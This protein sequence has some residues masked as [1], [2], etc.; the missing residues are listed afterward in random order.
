MNI[1]IF[2]VLLTCCLLLCGCGSNDPA[3]TPTSAPT[4]EPATTP[5]TQA[6]VIDENGVPSLTITQETTDPFEALMPELDFSEIDLPELPWEDDGVV[7]VPV[8]DPTDSD[9]DLEDDEVESTPETTNAVTPTYSD[10]LPEHVW[11]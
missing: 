6:P 8:T 7:A 3:A 1:R 4:T 10:T 9:T 5:T 2:L 11:E